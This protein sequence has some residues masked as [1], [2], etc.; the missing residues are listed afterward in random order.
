MFTGIVEEVGTVKQVRQGQHSA[1][2]EI[3]AGIV[4][5][6]AK[7]GDSIAVNGI[8]LTITSY[9]IIHLLQTLCMKL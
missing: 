5:E 7:I 6:D 2:L 8:C 3:Q 1:V 4:L 9:L